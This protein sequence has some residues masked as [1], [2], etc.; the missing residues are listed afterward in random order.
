MLD[1]RIPGIKETLARLRETTATINDL[2]SQIASKKSELDR[3]IKSKNN[4]KIKDELFTEKNTKNVELRELFEIEKKLQEKKNSLSREFRSIKEIV[5]SERKKYNLKSF[6]ELEARE[7]KLNMRII[8]GR[9]SSQEEREISNSLLEIKR[10]KKKMGALKE[11]DMKL[12]EMGRKLGKFSEEL[13]ANAEK[14]TKKKAEIEEINKKLSE[15]HSQKEK[16]TPE[17]INLENRINELINLKKEKIEV[18][19][20]IQ[21]ELKLLEEKYNSYKK[22]LEEQRRIEDEKKSLIERVKELKNTK[23]NLITNKNNIDPKKYDN[24]MAILKKFTKKQSELNLPP[25]VIQSLCELGAIIPKTVEDIPSCL[26]SMEKKKNEYKNNI[27][28][29]VKNMEEEL[30]KLDNELKKIQSKIDSMPATDFKVIK[31][32]YGIN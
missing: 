11:N 6:G 7:K 12:D 3:I 15:L 19:K 26:E 16:K 18:K 29:S 27:S 24:T 9:L 4:S 5:I 17:M 23:Q 21:E 8:G 2:E 1:R 14:I 32:K 10:M 25:S 20:S 13:K 30:T 31:K 22:E 28:Q